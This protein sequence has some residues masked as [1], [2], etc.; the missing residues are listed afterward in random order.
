LIHE[1]L[2]SVVPSELA[3]WTR[4]AN[5]ANREVGYEVANCI[6][7]SH[8]LAQ[9]LLDRGRSAILV[10]VA[11]QV[12]P[13]DRLIRGVNLGGDAPPGERLLKAPPGEW[14]G[15]LAVQCEGFLLDSTIDQ[16]TGEWP[17]IPPLVVPLPSGWKNGETVYVRL[18]EILLHWTYWLPQRGWKSAPAAQPIE[19][20]DI[21]DLMKS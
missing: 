14:N 16:A 9:F 8:A 15:H 18:G 7:V 6:G 4:A 2:S 3:D 21:L 12:R 19:W 11:A 5:R 17:P 1:D 20:R 13:D 10:R